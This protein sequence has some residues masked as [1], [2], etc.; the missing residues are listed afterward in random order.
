MSRKGARPIALPKGVEV[1]VSGTKVTVKG[2]KGT[3]SQEIA[4]GVKVAVLADKHEVTV[5]ME[6]E[7]GESSRIHG[8]YYSLINNMIQGVSTGFQKVLQLI[9]VGYRA[10][11]QGHLVDLQLGYSHPTKLHIPQGLKVEVE[12]NTRVI[13]S[14]VDKQAVGQ[15]AA[16][17][18]SV[19]PP[20]PYQGKG[21]RYEDE[22]VRRKAGKAGK[23]GGKK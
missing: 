21:V 18:R 5:H 23:A 16:D 3:L 1:S 8:L 14:G 11:V 7:T 10:A 9:G 13:I 12:K 19:R 2:P 22:Y 15:F 6:N 17:M 4:E 20:E